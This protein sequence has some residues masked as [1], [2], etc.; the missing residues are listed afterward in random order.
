M[1]VW[2]MLASLALLAVVI[3]GCVILG[4]NMEVS[5]EVPEQGEG[6]QITET[7]PASNDQ[8]ADEESDED[9]L[10]PDSSTV[11]EKTYSTGLAFR[12][13]GDGTCAV[14]GVGTCTA[15][16]ILIPPTSPAG[17]TV[18]E[19]LPFA[20]AGSTVGAIEVPETVTTLSAAS[21]S[22]CSRLALIRVASGHTAF[23]EYDGALY[24]ADGKTL[25][26]C[27]PARIQRELRLHEN[28]QRI[29]AAAFSDCTLLG[30]VYFSGNTAGWQALI[31]GDDNNALYA[32]SLKFGE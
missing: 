16:C 14:A 13:N 26:Y 15:A 2:K 4:Q 22:D 24:S 17:D 31:I 18:T 23:L 28:V 8:E 25:L 21:F 29:A 30:D 10:I 6:E 20:F 11:V 27:P 7:P 3:C 19:I 12:S 5:A 9:I 32:A 1:K